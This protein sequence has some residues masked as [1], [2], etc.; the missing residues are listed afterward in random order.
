MMIIWRESLLVLLIPLTLYFLH[1]IRSFH[2]CN[3]EGCCCCLLTPVKSPSV[4]PLLPVVEELDFFRNAATAADIGCC[5]TGCCID[6]MRA[7]AES[8]REELVDPFLL[9]VNTAFELL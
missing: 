7:L 8:L 3:A 2:P 1:E 5:A 6:W 9:S 4:V